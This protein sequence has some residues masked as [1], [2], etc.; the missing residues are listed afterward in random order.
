MPTQNNEI[1]DEKLREIRLKYTDKQLRKRFCSRLFD[2]LFRSVGELAM[3]PMQLRH[4]K[5]HIPVWVGYETLIG[6]NY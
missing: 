2:D 3:T 4:A 6:S 5:P 1:L